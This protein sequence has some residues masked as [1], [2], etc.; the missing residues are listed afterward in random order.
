MNS[1][2]YTFQFHRDDATVVFN[3]R[4]VVDLQKVPSNAKAKVHSAFQLHSPYVETNFTIDDSRSPFHV[5][6]ASFTPKTLIKAIIENH[7]EIEGMIVHE[8]IQEAYDFI[9]RTENVALESI[10]NQTL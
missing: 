1:T 4:I 6:F 3:G 7:L 5:E 2:A 10:R 8:D 9:T